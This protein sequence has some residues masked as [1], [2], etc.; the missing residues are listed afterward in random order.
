MNADL[1]R[2]F[3]T[4]KPTKVKKSGSNKPPKFPKKTFFTPFRV[5]I[6]LIALVILWSIVASGLHDPI[7]VMFYS[8]PSQVKQL[9]DQSGMNTH[10]KALFYST[11]PEIVDYPSLQQH[12]PDTAKDSIEFGCFVPSE[13]RIY[14]LNITDSRISSLMAVTAAHEMLHKAYS[15]LPESEKNR[16]DAELKNDASQLANDAKFNEIIGPYKDAKISESDLLDEMH[17]LIG[18]E[19]GT[20]DVPLSQ[21]Y[22]RYFA[23]RITSVGQDEKASAN[24]TAVSS[25]IDAQYADLQSKLSDLHGEEA[26]LHKFETALDYDIYIGDTYT[27]DINYQ[28]YSDIY[29]AY[30]S[31]FKQ[32]NSAVDAY[33]AKLQEY[34]AIFTNLKQAQTV[35]S[36]PE[37]TN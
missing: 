3:G 21:Y 15:E 30:D 6:G 14:I 31:H 18:S 11:R 17:S 1:E 5:T 34:Q 19:I 2:K 25:E 37:L 28:K 27:Y 32:Y 33:N 26:T 4:S 20:I 24:L 7:S 16:I 29:D 8:G 22:D 23:S 13:N 10:G 9:S 12:C 36:Q 35:S